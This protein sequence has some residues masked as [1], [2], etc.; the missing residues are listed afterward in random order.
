MSNSLANI[1]GNREFHEP[2]EIQTIKTYVRKEYSA[3]CIVKISDRYI[4]IQV[5]SAALAGSLRMQLHTL[6]EM[7]QT[8]K[9]LVIRIS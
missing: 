1:L 6:Q 9:R 5:D 3:D 7:C 2:P 8:K 4:T